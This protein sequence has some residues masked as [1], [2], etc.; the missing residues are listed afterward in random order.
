MHTT[1]NVLE[2]L[3]VSP[4][5]LDH[6]VSSGIVLRVRENSGQLYPEQQFNEHG[7]DAN[8]A[9]IVSCFK[10]TKLS[11]NSIWEWLNNPSEDFDGESPLD[12]LERTNNVDRIRFVASVNCDFT[13]TIDPSQSRTDWLKTGN[14]SS[15]DGIGDYTPKRRGGQNA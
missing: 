7:L 14:D 12:Y 9:S 13:S 8:F 10:K 4:T 11:G 6:L 1:D 2:L 15:E 5:T 3:N